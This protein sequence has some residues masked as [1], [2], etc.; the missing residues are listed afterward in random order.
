MVGFG[1]V[2]WKQLFR[3]QDEGAHCAAAAMFLD[4]GYLSEIM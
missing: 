2:A 4:I 1:K 3:N